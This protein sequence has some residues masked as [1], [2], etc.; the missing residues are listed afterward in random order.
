MDST[1][2]CCLCDCIQFHTPTATPSLLGAVITLSIGL[3]NQS[4][5]R[6]KSQRCRNSNEWRIYTPVFLA[7]V[8][9]LLLLVVAYFS[10]V[11]FVLTKGDL[12]QGKLAVSLWHVCV[13]ELTEENK[14]NRGGK[15]SESIFGERRAALKIFHDPNFQM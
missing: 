7:V 14:I 13:Y 1:V 8:A 10:S 15:K 3:W 9:V 2:Q 5:S 12:S 11:N 6:K 4:Y